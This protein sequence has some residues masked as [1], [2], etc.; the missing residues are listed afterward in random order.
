MSALL[1]ALFGCRRLGPCAAS[2]ILHI[3]QVPS[4]SEGY[5][6]CSAALLIFSRQII[7]DSGGTTVFWFA[8]N[9][10]NCITSLPVSV[11]ETA[12]RRHRSCVDLE[13]SNM[14]GPLS[15]DFIRK[16]KKEETKGKKDLDKGPP[17][18]G[19]NRT[20]GRLHPARHRR[21]YHSG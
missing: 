6:V 8:A 20:S 14:D 18:E 4:W 10:L 5:Q 9:D 19:L 16:E 3:S 12:L 21:V 15:A 17:V 1:S 2:S 11:I 7:I 13:P